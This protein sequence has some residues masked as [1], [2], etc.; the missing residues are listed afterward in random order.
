MPYDENYSNDAN[1]ADQDLLDQLDEDL[2][3]L[4]ELADA[5]ADRLDAQVSAELDAH[6]QH[7]TITRPS[8]K[9]SLKRPTSKTVNRPLAQVIKLA[10][11]R[12][13]RD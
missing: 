13:G 12:S 10:D 8:T 1:E 11:R 3:R 7:P 6:I 4:A 5:E 2:M 9:H